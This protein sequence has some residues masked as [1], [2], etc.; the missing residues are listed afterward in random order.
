M[1]TSVGYASIAV[2]D[3]LDSE[4][5]A[6]EVVAVTPDL[7][8]LTGAWLFK[9]DEIE[10]LKQII[11]GR[12]ILKI[13]KGNDLDKILSNY[14]NCEIEIADFLFEARSEVASSLKAFQEFVV[15]NDSDY[16]AYMAISASERK[17]I[18]K[19]TKKLLSNPDFFNWPESFENTDASEYLESIGKN[20]VIK[21]GDPEFAQTLALAR[22]IKLFIERWKNDEIERKNKI[23]VDIDNSNITILPNCWLSKV[24]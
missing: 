16:R 14:K 13:K 18:P 23:Y 19:V 17:N 6:I 4:K 20:G 1:K 8:E 2:I 5:I 11:E 3:Y 21:G 7:C 24:K 15:K 12:L 22:T 10:T 9:K